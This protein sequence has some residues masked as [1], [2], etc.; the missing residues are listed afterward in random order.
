MS[1]LAVC[2]HLTRFMP[3]LIPSQ[4]RIASSGTSS[5]VVPRGWTCSQL[6]SYARSS[7]EGRSKPI[8]E[9]L[10][11]RDVGACPIRPFSTTRRA[12]QNAP[13]SASAMP[14]PPTSFHKRQEEAAESLRPILDELPNEIDFAVAYGSGVMKQANPTG[15]SRRRLSSPRTR[16]RTLPRPSSPSLGNVELTKS[17]H[18]Q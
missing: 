10:L 11:A 1:L 14:T 18:R 17:S 5:S 2:S 7:L 3:V 6:H 13:A 4:I 15:V 12:R 8:P 9:H 16:S